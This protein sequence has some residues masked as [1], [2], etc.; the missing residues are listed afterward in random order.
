MSEFTG[1][2]PRTG[3]PTEPQVPP[4]QTERPATSDPDEMVDTPDELGGTGGPD[5]GGAG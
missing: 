4:A 5:A 3:H 1:T 2:A